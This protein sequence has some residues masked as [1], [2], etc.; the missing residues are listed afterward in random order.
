MPIFNLL[1]KFFKKILIGLFLS[2]IIYQWAKWFFP[3]NEIAQK[4]IQQYEKFL[5]FSEEVLKEKIPGL[6]NYFAE[7]EKEKQQKALDNLMNWEWNILDRMWWAFEAMDK[8]VMIQQWILV[9]KNPELAKD[10]STAWVWDVMKSIEAMKNYKEMEAEI[11]EDAWISDDESYMT[12]QEIIQYWK[13]I[14]KIN[15]WEKTEQD[16]IDFLW[17]LSKKS[18]ET[19]D[20]KNSLLKISEEKKSENWWDLEKTFDET[21]NENFLI[22]E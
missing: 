17:N 14:E 6:E 1:K 18:Q 20:L 22:A 5:A 4:Y 3:E 12:F 7:S 13:L 2:F 11:Y 9:L 10:F 15:N 16:L 21:M 19:E 8:Y